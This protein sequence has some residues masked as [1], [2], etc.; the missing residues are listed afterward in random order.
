MNPTMKRISIEDRDE[1]VVVAPIRV[2]KWKPRKEEGLAAMVSVFLVDLSMEGD[3]RDLR[4]IGGLPFLGCD[5]LISIVYLHIGQE[6][7]K[8]RVIL[9]YSP[10]ANCLFVFLQNV[11][12]NADDLHEYL[13]LIV[14]SCWK[15]DPNARLDFSRTIQMLLHYLSYTTNSLPLEPAA[16][17]PPQIF[18]VFVPDS[19]QK[20]PYRRNLV[21]WITKPSR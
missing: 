12:T 16:A 5:I 17:I 19:H 1:G 4:Q 20:R 11:R 3:L 10:L 14:T 8:S 9:R 2:R 18:D 15:E 13:A 7:Q 21:L 6:I